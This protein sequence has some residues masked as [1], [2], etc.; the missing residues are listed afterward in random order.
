MNSPWRKFMGTVHG[1]SMGSPWADDWPPMWGHERS[2]DS[3]WCLH[4]GS[5]DSQG[6]VHEHSVKSLWTV[7]HSTSRVGLWWSIVPPWCV[8]GQSTVGRW[9][10][11]EQSMVGRWAVHEQSM[12]S[13]WTHYGDSPSEVHGRSKGSSWTAHGP[14]MVGSWTLRGQFMVPP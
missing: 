4:G 14:S 11:H 9:T 12:D 8:D 6:R 3:P 2:M 5:M 13:P 10:V 1:R 7:V